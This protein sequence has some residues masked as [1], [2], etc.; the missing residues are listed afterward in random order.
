MSFPDAP[1]LDVLQTSL[2]KMENCFYL[3][4]SQ[5]PQGTDW[6]S[7]ADNWRHV[8]KPLVLEKEEQVD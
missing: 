5:S 1:H 2:R 7:W 6:C 4:S 8:V 3:Q